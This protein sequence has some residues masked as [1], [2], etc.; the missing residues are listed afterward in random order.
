M[1]ATEA[2]RSKTGFKKYTIA[3]GIT[4]G[5]IIFLFSY[6][7][8]LEFKAVIKSNEEKGT[9]LVRFLGNSIAEPLL[10]DDYFI[11]HTVLA[12][13]GRSEPELAYA[14][15]LD[16]NGQLVEHTF[17]GQ[18]PVKLFAVHN[19]F[20]ND[21]RVDVLEVDTEIGRIR[22]FAVSVIV[23]DR[24]IGTAVVGLSEDAFTERLYSF[25]LLQFAVLTALLGTLAAGVFFLIRLLHGEMRYS[26]SDLE[27]CLRKM[28][29]PE[30]ADPATRSSQ[31]YKNSNNFY[32]YFSGL[33]SEAQQHLETLPQL[34]HER[35]NYRHIMHGLL[36]GI[37]D[38]LIIYD[39]EGRIIAVNHAFEKYFWLNADTIKGK[40]P[41]EVISSKVGIIARTENEA[42]LNGAHSINKEMSANING[43]G[44]IFHVNRIPIKDEQGD[45][46]YILSIMTDITGF[47][48]TL[49]H[50]ELYKLYA[51][52]V[53]MINKATKDLA[54]LLLQA[55]E[56][57]SPDHGQSGKMDLEKLESILSSCR[58]LVLELC[59]IVPRQRALEEPVNIVDSIQQSINETH[60]E[61]KNLGMQTVLK[62]GETSL[63]VRGNEGAFKE[64][65]H[66]LLFSAFE[67]MQS[68]SR[69]KAQF[70]AFVDRDEEKRE[71][72][73]RWLSSCASLTASDVTCTA[74]LLNCISGDQDI[75]SFTE[76]LTKLP[77][78]TF[79]K[80]L[81]QTLGRT[82]NQSPGEAPPRT[83]NL[84]IINK[85]VQLYGGSLE[86]T[87][88]APRELFNS[89]D[90]EDL[91][92]DLGPGTLLTIR[93]PLSENQD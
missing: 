81:E 37:P 59:Q 10:G 73:I 47:K 22:S 49:K 42:I 87:S 12:D 48:E 67:A 24:R 35:D 8:R 6:V 78:P 92:D 2:K 55:Q 77:S 45:V 80:N 29:S 88:P 76:A 72:V 82:A 61:F 58:E 21:N 34:S 16:K 5:F 60:D 65:W 68:E 15:I 4:V 62:T 11:I 74:Q 23:A 66:S 3:L 26:L 18:F 57:F 44:F 91:G 39:A 25:I 33:L 89:N 20:H 54:G 46:R 70:A 93:L 64:I 31:P 1:N 69:L 85:I 27:Q 52:Y 32:K 36:K 90:I 14:F 17:K 84:T 43:D 79:A 30:N 50:Q 86:L 63:L 51:F 7:L 38:I 71:V 53:L 56:H 13:L 28:P 41:D 40:Y 75:Q 83:L 19:N 9:A